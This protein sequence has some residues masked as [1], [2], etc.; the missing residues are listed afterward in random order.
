[1]SNTTMNTTEVVAANM[2][3][4]TK[5]SRADRVRKFAV[6]AGYSSDVFNSRE[7]N[8]YTAK[9]YND[10]ANGA[11]SLWDLAEKLFL[12]SEDISAGLYLD[13]D[14]IK[15]FRG[16]CTAVG[17]DVSNMSKYVRAYKEYSML[18]D[19]G[20]TLGIAVKLLGSGIDGYDFIARYKPNEVTSR[21]VKDIISKSKAIEV[22]TTDEKTDEKETENVS[23]NTD[24]NATD[25]APA[26]SDDSGVKYVMSYNV[27]C[28]LIQYARENTNSSFD[29]IIAR[30]KAEF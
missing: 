21:N 23:E 17:F 3:V 20:F 7:L 9:V 18:R 29:D 1:M 26:S 27:L 30:F 11:V 14:G 19:A 4:S 24:E 12:I 2:G 22:T 6:S 28:S 8:K 5:V 10:F 15:S 13:S 16:Y 25:K